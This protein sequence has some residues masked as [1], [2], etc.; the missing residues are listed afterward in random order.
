MSCGHLNEQL[1]GHEEHMS[2]QHKVCIVQVHTDIP[3][4]VYC[5]GGI[6][7]KLLCMST[8][9]ALADPVQTNKH[10]MVDRNRLTRAVQPG[11]ELHE[12]QPFCTQKQMC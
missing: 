10:L 2:N 7:E 6:L 12:M 11:M 4:L 3:V 5:G 8:G 1:S 9:T